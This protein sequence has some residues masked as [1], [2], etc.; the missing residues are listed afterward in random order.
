MAAAAAAATVVVVVVSKL[1]D[2][3]AEYFC[4]DIWSQKKVGQICRLYSAITCVCIHRKW[5]SDE[6]ALLQCQ[7]Q[8]A[9]E[10]PVVEM[11]VL[12]AQR[13]R[14]KQLVLLPLFP[15]DCACC[16]VLLVFLSQEPKLIHRTSVF[17]Q[18][19]RS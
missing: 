12:R 18:C 3:T 16:A 9:P 6:I 17:I 11:E 4:N 1:R 2:F 14:L 8:S 10:P 5:L 7:A 15:R 13:L 19:G